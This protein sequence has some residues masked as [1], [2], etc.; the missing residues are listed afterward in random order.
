MAAMLREFETPA[1]WMRRV[2]LVEVGDA[3]EEAPKKKAKPAR[4][5]A[6]RK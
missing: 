2:H 4:K 6:R 5:K 3:E 1:Q